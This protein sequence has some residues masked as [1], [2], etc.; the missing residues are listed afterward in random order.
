MS[1]IKV[2]VNEAR[3]AMKPMHA[4]N[5][6][7]LGFII[8]SQNRCNFEEYRAAR[9]PY[10][11]NHDASEW[12]DFGGEFV[13]DIYSIFPNF[14]ADPDDP[15]SYEFTVTDA[16]TKYTQDAGTETF[17]RL[18]SR[19][20]HQP[21]KFR[22]IMPRDFH[23]WAVVCEHVIRHYN[24]GWADGFHYNIQYWEIWNEPDL[25][26]D[27]VPTNKKR[28]WSGTAA[29]F[30]E[31]YEVVATYL[32]SRFPDLKIGGPALASKTGAWTDGFL[33]HM[34]ANGKH[35]PL[36]FFSWHWYGTD[37][38]NML[39]RAHTVRNKLDAAGYHDAESILNE[40]NY[41]ANWGDRWTDTVL[42]IIGPRGA[43]FLAAIL[44]EGQNDPTVDMM[45]YYDAA[46]CTLNGIFDFYTCKPIMGYWA[47]YAFS[48]LC[49]LGTAVRTVCDGQDIYAVAAR[50][51]SGE[52]ATLITYY[53]PEDGQGDRTMS[54]SLPDVSDARTEILVIED[55][56]GYRSR[57]WQEGETV[58]LT[59]RPNSFA[60]LRTVSKTEGAP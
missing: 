37:P 15:A 25:D 60:L 38:A 49:E 41:V 24:E 7:P 14:D 29:Q 43:A 3:G 18:G 52:V 39:S 31:F 1:E 45:M 59:M 53:A 13:V 6:G 58:T 20:E 23:K 47:I 11:R 12:V 22:T 4:V 56:Q 42:Q 40:W 17:Y 36:D 16:Y 48:D 46:P 57:G 34:T 21:K 32:K 35:V 50:N 26:G 19:I 44:C 51:E 55:A 33:T 10:A 54:V 5:K 30:Y 28:T 2:Y 8:P 9:I 27:D